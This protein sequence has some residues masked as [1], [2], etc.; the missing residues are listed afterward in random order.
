MLRSNIIVMAVACVLLMSADGFAR[1]RGGSRGSLPRGG[2]RQQL[3]RRP[4]VQPHS[5]VQRQPVS[6][7]AGGHPQRSLQG[8]PG[9]AGSSVR[10]GDLEHMRQE[11]QT[12]QYIHRQ[13]VERDSRYD[14]ETRSH[15]VQDDYLYPGKT[16][17]P[18]V[19]QRIQ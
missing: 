8:A 9:G 14:D 6:G 15:N 13:Q 4:A 7:A 2:N 17:T 11:R 5:P 12:Q 10:S 1:D 3:D 16:L 18:A 19:P